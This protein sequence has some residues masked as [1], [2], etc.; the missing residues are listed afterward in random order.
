MVKHSE[1]LCALTA[2]KTWEDRQATWYQ[3]RHDG[4]RRLVRPF[5]NAADMHFPL[6]DMQVEKLKPLYVQQIFATDQLATFAALTNEQAQYQAAVAQWFDFQTKQRTNFEEEIFSG[7]DTMLVHAKAIVKVR[8]DVEKKRVAYEAINPIYIIVPPGTE[9]LADADWI[10]HVQHFSKAQYKQREAWNQDEAFVKS[11]CGKGTDTNR[12]EDEKLN[13]E[14]LTEG[15]S[16]EDIVVWEVFY[17]N[18][19]GKWWIK[20]YCPV[21]P[22]D[23][24]RNDFGLPYNQGVFGEN[25][26]PFGELNAE[27]K[28]KGYYSPRGVPERVAPFEAALNKD[29]NTQKDYQTLTCTPMFSAKG[30]LPTGTQNIRMIPGEVVPFEVNAVQFPSMP[31][32]IGM[33]MQMTRMT[34]EQAIAAPDFGAA[35]NAPGQKPRT[36]TEMNMVGGMANQTSD[37]RSRIFRRELGYL[38]R[39][40]WA[41]YIQ[42]AKEQ[43]QFFFDGELGQLKPEALNDK[44]LI[45]PSGSGDNINRQ[46]VM[47]RAVARMQMFKGDPDIEQR[48]LKK[49]VLEADDPRLV[50]RLL[51]NA[52][53][54]AAMQKEDQAVEITTMLIGFQSEVRETDDDS[55]HVQCL[56]EFI[57]RRNTMGEPLSAEQMRL[58]AQHGQIHLQAMKKKNPQGFAQAAPVAGPLFQ[59]LMA[60]AQQV[61]QVKQQQAAMRA[62]GA[63]VDVQ[64]NVV[65]MPAGGVA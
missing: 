63:P 6:A 12:T 25:V 36:A 47:A 57:Q 9:K 1:I 23:K 61:D 2:R 37:L 3:M 31:M 22:R 64:S 48:E 45:E 39:M 59:E 65:P 13:R 43:L 5:P 50:K 27:V 26:P 60:L 29:W 52:G 49:S 19:E 62:Q 40:A 7:V 21:R 10:V 53:T 11:L 38:F 44:F 16:D 33:Q 42:Y 32:D 54:Q 34:A 8:W 51:L 4:L 24:L 15:K 30:G 18:A 17:R 46:F 14:G 28:D 20:T 58:F 55:A 56:M 35:Q 41:L